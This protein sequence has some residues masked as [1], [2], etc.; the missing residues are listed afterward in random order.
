MCKKTLEILTKSMVIHVLYFQICY[1]IG[2]FEQA[3]D[4]FA[5]VGG[6]KSSSCNIL[7]EV[8]LSL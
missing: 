3:G 2:N 5:A 8:C 6:D 7:S 1:G 4:T